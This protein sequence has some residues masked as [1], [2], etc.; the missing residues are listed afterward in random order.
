MRK[1]LAERQ[2]S[3]RERTASVTEKRPVQSVRVAETSETP[4]TVREIAELSCLPAGTPVSMLLAPGT[5]ATF[6]AS[7]TLST[8]FVYFAK[9]G[10]FVFGSGLAVV[11][12]PVR[13]SGA[14]APLA[15]H[16]RSVRLPSAGLRTS[17]PAT[18]KFVVLSISI[19]IAEDLR[20]QSANI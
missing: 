11:A 17:T 4:Y 7:G 16:R 13:W 1:N 15:E 19:G 8:I 12:L 18:H 6:G 5:L 2:A 10:L 3:M 14:R 9:A 20:D